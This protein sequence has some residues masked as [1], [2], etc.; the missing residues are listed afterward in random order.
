MI[1]ASEK[2]SKEPPAEAEA[3]AEDQEMQDSPSKG[4]RDRNKLKRTQKV[5]TQVSSVPTQNNKSDEEDYEEKKKP[6][7]KPKER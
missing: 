6:E 5:A 7:R 4:L 3:D 2:S 1:K